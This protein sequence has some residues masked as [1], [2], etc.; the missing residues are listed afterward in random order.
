MFCCIQ[1]QDGLSIDSLRGIESAQARIPNVESD[2][3]RSSACRQDSF[4]NHKMIKLPSGNRP[5]N[6]ILTTDR[7]MEQERQRERERKS[8]REKDKEILTMSIY[9]ESL[10]KGNGCQTEFLL[11][12]SQRVWP[13]S[14]NLSSHRVASVMRILRKAT[15]KWTRGLSGTGPHASKLIVIHFQALFCF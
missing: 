3:I 11:R 2:Q 6:G 1:D 4:T 13:R 10:E 5:F 15:S 8:E 12:F 14:P 7:V 9:L